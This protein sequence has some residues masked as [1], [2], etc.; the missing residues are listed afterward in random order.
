MIGAVVVLVS[1]AETML[2]FLDPDE[3]FAVGLVHASV[4]L[5]RR[6]MAAVLVWRRVT[7]PALRA[8]GSLPRATARTSAW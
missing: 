3:M 4:L 6:M 8:A 7:Q 5:G 2:G 1:D